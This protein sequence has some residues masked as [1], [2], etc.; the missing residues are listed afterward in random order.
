MPSPEKPS[1][2]LV[3]DNEATRTL[4]IALLQ[5]EFQI[6]SATDGMEAIEKL[7]TN[8]YGCIL[9]DLRM[10]QHDGFSVLEFLQAN[11]PH[12][13]R[14]VLVV[15]ALL[16]KHEIDR[17][18]AFGICGII[19]K[20]FDVDELLGA[21]KECASGTDGGKL[22][23]VFCTSTPMILLIADLLRQRLG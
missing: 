5:R 10:P 16:A 1:V 4:M 22:G 7:R 6:D 14:T 13:L 9:L 23:N 19:T 20:P 15:T 12:S 2:L 17:A 8:Q 3:D 11:S 18:K 21:V